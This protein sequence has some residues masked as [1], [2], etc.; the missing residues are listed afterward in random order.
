MIE[1]REAIRLARK[2]NGNRSLLVHF[3]DRA[4]MNDA[5][6]IALIKKIIPD[7]TTPDQL[8]GLLSIL[9]NKKITVNFIELSNGTQHQD[10]SEGIVDAETA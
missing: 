3:V 9:E 6:L 4:Y 2:K 8:P 10:S 1:L 5:V 7:K